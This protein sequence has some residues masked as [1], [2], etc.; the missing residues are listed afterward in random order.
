VRR[1]WVGGE[2]G[3]GWHLT[4]NSNS[5]HVRGKV[6]RW[7]RQW[8]FWVMSRRWGRKVGLVCGELD[9]EV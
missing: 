4:S 7:R 6:V 3:V 1:E 2:E 8:S 5:M 9:G